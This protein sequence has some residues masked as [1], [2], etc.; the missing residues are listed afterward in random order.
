MTEEEIEKASRLTP[1][2][3]AAVDSLIAAL[4]ALP[5]SLT[6]D[7]DDMDCEVIVAKRITRRSTRVVASLRKK[8][9]FLL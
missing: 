6:L 4:R 8:S 5:Q 9:L 1:K 3:K 2:E 7:I